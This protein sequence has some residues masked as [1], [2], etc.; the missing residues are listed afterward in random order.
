MPSPH[1]REAVSVVKKASALSQ[2]DWLFARID[3][4]PIFVASCWR[5]AHTKDTV[6]AV[7]QDLA[8]QR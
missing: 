6:L 2:G 4:V 7:K 3:Q 1:Q 8:V 5:G